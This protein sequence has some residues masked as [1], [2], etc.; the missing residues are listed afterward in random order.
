MPDGLV[1]TLHI[2]LASAPT[3]TITSISSVAQTTGAIKG[4]LSV[5]TIS[6]QRAIM[7]TIG[8]FIN[9]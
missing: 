8:A 9:V 1:S 4:P 6:I 2:L 5:N 7:A 3:C